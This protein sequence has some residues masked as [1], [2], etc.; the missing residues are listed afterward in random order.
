MSWRTTLGK[1]QLWGRGAQKKVS[2]I[3]PI[4]AK[5]YG[6]TVRNSNIK[7][8][9]LQEH[10]KRRFER[11]KTDVTPI[12]L[13][14]PKNE[15]QS[16]LETQRARTKRS[17]GPV[18]KL[19]LKVESGSKD[20]QNARAFWSDRIKQPESFYMLPNFATQNPVELLD[21]CNRCFW[22][23][24]RFLYVS[25]KKFTPKNACAVVH[26]FMD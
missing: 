26:N 15:G 23:D 17:G 18:E 2:A 6:R 12:V 24:R 25:L 8:I 20:L 19:S 5:R 16:Q 10:L 7:A 21:D 13:K 22:E 3:V 1:Q 11:A 9:G 14:E 4:E